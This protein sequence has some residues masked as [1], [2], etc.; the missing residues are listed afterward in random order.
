EVHPLRPVSTP[1]GPPLG[2]RP[3]AT[4]TAVEAKIVPGDR[5]VFYTD[6]LIEAS[7]AEQEPFGEGRLIEAGRG[8]PGVGCGRL[9]DDILAEV[10]RFAQGRGFADDVCLVGADIR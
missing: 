8:R 7:N 10:G 1:S 9:F 6:G 2:V 5:L 4:Y 3:Q